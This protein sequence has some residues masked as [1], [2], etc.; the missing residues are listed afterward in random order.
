[1]TTTYLCPNITIETESVGANN[2]YVYNYKG[3]HYRV[4]DSSENL[5]NFLDIEKDTWIFECC[6]ENELEEYLN[7]IS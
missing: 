6:T 3:I 2:F 5:Q 1:M 7:G 4:F